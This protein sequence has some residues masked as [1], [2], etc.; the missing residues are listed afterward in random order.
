MGSFDKSPRSDRRSSSGRLE[1]SWRLKQWCSRSEKVRLQCGGDSLLPLVA[2]NRWRGRAGGSP[3]ANLSPL[4][5]PFGRAETR[6]VR[7]MKTRAS[8]KSCII[9]GDEC[10]SWVMGEENEIP[11]ELSNVARPAI[12]TNIVLILSFTLPRYVIPPATHGVFL[13]S[14]LHAK[15]RPDEIPEQRTPQLPVLQHLPLANRVA[16]A[17][18]TRDGLNRRRLGPSPRL[19]GQVRRGAS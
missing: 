3:L 10:L 16:S 8:V 1:P 2:S 4:D 18:R 5:S 6:V 9:A 19:D 12:I 13:A 17:R 14:F 15:I 11:F 7:K